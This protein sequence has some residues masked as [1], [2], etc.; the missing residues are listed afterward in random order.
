[1]HVQRIKFTLCPNY[2]IFGRHQESNVLTVFAH[3]LP[4][5]EVFSTHELP[6]KRELGPAFMEY[7][8]NNFSPRHEFRFTSEPY[9]QDPSHIAIMTFHSPSRENNIVITFTHMPLKFNRALRETMS[10][11]LEQGSELHLSHMITSSFCV[12]KTARRA[13][14][15]NE[16]WNGERS[17][18]MKIS[19]TGDIRPTVRNLVPLHFPLP[20]DMNQIISLCFDEALGRLCIGLYS[21][22]VVIMDLWVHYLHMAVIGI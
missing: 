18:F 22:G 6:T 20:F 3:A 1:M 16:D 12:G 13:V 8:I 7:E 14:W 15:F 5:G 2:I 17:R 21:E 9:Y 19:I 11:Q 10:T 4:E